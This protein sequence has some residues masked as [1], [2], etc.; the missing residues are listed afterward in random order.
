MPELMK[1]YS[2][3]DKNVN[4][5][6]FSNGYSSFSVIEMK[7]VQNSVTYTLYTARG[8]GMWIKEKENIFSKNPMEGNKIQSSPIRSAARQRYN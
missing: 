1:Q 5:I 8:K 6:R 4:G 3:D 2:K 7:A